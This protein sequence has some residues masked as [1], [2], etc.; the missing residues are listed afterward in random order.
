MVGAS[1]NGLCFDCQHSWDPATVTAG[2][3]PAPL[4]QPP[5]VIG[6]VDTGE[7]PPVPLLAPFDMAT[8]EEVYGSIAEPDDRT[9]TFPPEELIGGTARLE[10]GQLATV[11]SFPSIDSVEV[12]LNDGRTEIVDFSDVE[13]ITPRAPAPATDAVDVPVPAEYVDAVE[14]LIAER[15]YDKGD[16]NE[17]AAAV[18]LTGELAVLIVKAAVASMPDAARPGEIVPVPIGFLPDDP[19]LFP[20][21]EQAAVQAVR[22]VIAVF[23]LDAAVLLAAVG[24]GDEEPNQGDPQ[25]EEHDDVS[26]SNDE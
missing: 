6:I 5:G 16:G 1:G 22:G 2:P 11:V 21:V 24:L 19:G 12:V 14:S 17:E 18:K 23:E 9:A 26:P 8:V 15:E 4:N 3:K 10:G 20:I 7:P 13:R 25:Q